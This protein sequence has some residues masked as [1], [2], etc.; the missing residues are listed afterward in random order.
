MSLYP[1]SSTI[2]GQLSICLVLGMLLGEFCQ[3]APHSLVN[4]GILHI[5]LAGKEYHKAYLLLCAGKIFVEQTLAAA[6]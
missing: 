3:S 4:C 2:N 6:E 5:G 1:L